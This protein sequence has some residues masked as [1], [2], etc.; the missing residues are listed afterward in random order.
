LG[1]G[2]AGFAVK[3][4]VAHLPAYKRAVYG[5]KRQPK[6]NWIGGS[7]PASAQ[8]VP[9]KVLPDLSF[10]GVNS[11]TEHKRVRA[12]ANRSF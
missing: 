4:A 11:G 10:G 12:A 8:L 1:E 5:F 9:E 7:V 3:Q 2:L 6:D